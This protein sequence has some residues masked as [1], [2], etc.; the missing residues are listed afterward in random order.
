LNHFREERTL[1][2]FCLIAWVHR[3]PR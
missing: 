1:N 3:L 2:L